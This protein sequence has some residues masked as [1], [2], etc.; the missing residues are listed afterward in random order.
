MC[1]FPNRNGPAEQGHSSKVGVCWFYNRRDNSTRWLS[2]RRLQAEAGQIALVAGDLGARHQEAV[3]GGH[4]AGEQR[5]GGRERDGGGLGHL[6]P[7]LET[8]SDAVSF[9]R[10]IYV[11][12]MPVSMHAIAWQH[13]LS[14]IAT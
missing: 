9:R 10:A 2:P 7:F 12:Q 5:G 3:D 8:V 6:N 4:E 13:S 14:R 11:Y 1:R